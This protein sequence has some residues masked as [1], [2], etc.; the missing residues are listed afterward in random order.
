MPGYKHPC[1]Y[2]SGLTP[3]ESNVCP[4]C[5]KV[6]PLGPERCPKCKNPVE[7]NWKSCSNCGL[8]LEVACPKCGKTTFFGDYCSQCGERLLVTCNNPKCKT[9]QPPSGAQCVKC[10]KPL[11]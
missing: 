2:C 3:A 6:N 7:N 8:L 4:L 5:G 1:R 9:E 11:K 10:G